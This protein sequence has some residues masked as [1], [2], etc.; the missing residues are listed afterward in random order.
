MSISP[1]RVRLALEQLGPESGFE[2]ERFANA[3]LAVEIPDLWPVGGVH[4]WWSQRIHLCIRR[5]TPCFLS[6]L[7]KGLETKSR[8]HSRHWRATA[9]SCVMY[10]CLRAKRGSIWALVPGQAL[11]PAIYLG[12][13]QA[14]K[15]RPDV[16]F[17]GSVRVIE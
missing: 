16:R 12:G 10:A 13:V 14:T 2:F 4:D 17:T 9:S 7:R 8:V 15:A 3:L 1:E 11:T 6:A 5:G